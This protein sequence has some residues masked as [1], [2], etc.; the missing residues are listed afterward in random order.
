MNTEAETFTELASC[1]FGFGLE[2]N[3]G[4]ATTSQQENNVE[5]PTML[6]ALWW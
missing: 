6:E 1:D 4:I 3:T 2:W 5:D